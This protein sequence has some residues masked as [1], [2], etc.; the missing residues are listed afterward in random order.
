MKDNNTELFGNASLLSQTSE[1]QQVEREYGTEATSKL[2]SNGFKRTMNKDI[3]PE[4]CSGFLE[5]T[6][7]FQN[8]DAR[9]GY[10][11]KEEENKVAIMVANKIKE[12]FEKDK[13]GV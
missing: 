8:N 5:I 3:S 11:I 1:V 13:E 2:M 10:A 9:L 12:I 4:K 7:I 6:K